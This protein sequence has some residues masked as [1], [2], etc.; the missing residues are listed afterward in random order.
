MP[1]TKEPCY[2]DSCLPPPATW[3]WV[4]DCLNRGLSRGEIVGRIASG[5]DAIAEEVRWEQRHA[6]EAATRLAQAARLGAARRAAEA[7]RR[8]R[9]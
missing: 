1:R 6:K 7:R 3:D 2:V 4:R 9:D 5:I 8:K